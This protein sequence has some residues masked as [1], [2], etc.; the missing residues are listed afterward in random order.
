MVSRSGD[1]GVE[2]S[3]STQKQNRISLSKNVNSLERWR[4]R[5]RER[6]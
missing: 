3:Q 4:E 5:E 2:I 6:E 1:K